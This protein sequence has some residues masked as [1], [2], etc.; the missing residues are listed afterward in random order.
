[1]KAAS[2]YRLTPLLV[3][4]P[5]MLTGGADRLGGTSWSRILGVL[6]I[7]LGVAILLGA[8][9]EIRDGRRRKRMSDE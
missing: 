4:V 2:T 1:M 6:E 7:A 9:K 3:F 8:A 5:F